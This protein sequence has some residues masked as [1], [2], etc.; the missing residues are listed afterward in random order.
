MKAFENWLYE[1]ND[2]ILFAIVCC[3]ALG[4]VYVFIRWMFRGT[5]ITPETKETLH[6]ATGR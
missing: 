4:A 2:W 6:D 5:E 3:L 1:T